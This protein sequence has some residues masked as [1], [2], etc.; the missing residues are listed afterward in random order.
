VRASVRFADVRFAIVGC[1]NAA[2]HIHLPAL[3]SAGAAVTVTTPPTCAGVSV[4]ST[5]CVLEVCTLTSIAAS[6]NVVALLVVAAIVA[7]AFFVVV[8]GRHL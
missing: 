3:R 8:V 5:T 1:G 2:M 7:V 4:I 6:P